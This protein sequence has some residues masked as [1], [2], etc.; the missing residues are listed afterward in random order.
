V[1]AT[2]GATALVLGGPPLGEDLV[3]FWNFVARTRAEAAIAAEQWN[4]HD[5]RFGAVESTLQ[6]IAAPVPPWGS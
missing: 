6:R 3:M 4:A 1:K 2:A 5:P